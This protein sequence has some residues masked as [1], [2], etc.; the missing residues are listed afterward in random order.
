[1]LR[2]TS[3]RQRMFKYEEE[4]SWYR[5]QI[6]LEPKRPRMSHSGDLGSPEGMTMLSSPGEHIGPDGRILE[7]HGGYM[8]GDGSHAMET[9]VKEEAMTSALELR[10]VSPCCTCVY[11]LH[12]LPLWCMQAAMG[13]N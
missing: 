9:P 1:M 6:D 11:G 12:R 10:Y 2:P 4:M 13:G 7:E 3:Q 8:M 5:S